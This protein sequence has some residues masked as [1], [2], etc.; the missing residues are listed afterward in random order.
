MMAKKISKTKKKT[1]RITLG[2]GRSRSKKGG[3]GGSA[4]ERL[5][6]ILKVLVVVGVIVAVGAAVFFLQRYVGVGEK[7]GRLELVNKPDWVT[8]ELVEKVHLRAAAD[9]EDFRLDEDAAWSVCENLRALTWLEDV[10]VRTTADAILIDAKFRRP[11]CWIAAG[12]KKF[13]LDAELVVLDFLPLPKAAV[14]EVKGALGAIV[15][16]V[17]QLWR[18]DDLAAAVKII[19]L[20]EEMDRSIAP[21]KPLLYEIADIDVR[22]YGGRRNPDGPH[23]L[24]HAKD[25]T[26]IRWGAQVGSSGRYMEA[27]E[28]EKLNQ[29]YG[30]YEDHGTLQEI[31]KYIELRTPRKRIPRPGG[32]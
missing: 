32:E 23:I 28:A 15:P 30:L 14:I 2:S 18:R 12:G 13:Y 11:V 21:V 7:I 25:G 31:A 19:E 5:V 10:R 22:N 20:L 17:G 1:S 16:V 4:V 3:K 9:G 6:M 29:L 27:A 26:E 8:A 24:L